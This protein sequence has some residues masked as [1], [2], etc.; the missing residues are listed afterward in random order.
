MQLPMFRS[1][2]NHDNSNRIYIAAA[3][4]LLCNIGLFVALFFVV[5]PGKPV[6]MA[7]SR[8]GGGRAI[9]V[10][11]KKQASKPQPHHNAQ[12]QKSSVHK[13]SVASQPKTPKQ[14]KSQ[15]HKP[16]QS[17]HTTEKKQPVKQ[18]D[19]Q[20]QHKPK[21]QQQQSQQKKPQQQKS[22]SVQHKSTQNKQNT[23]QASQQQKQQKQTP[24]S[25]KQ[26]QSNTASQQ[27]PQKTKQSTQEQKKQQS[28]AQ[29]ETKSADVSESS[30]PLNLNSEDVSDHV[31][32]AMV[33]E[34]TK[35]WHPPAGLGGTLSCQVKVALTHNGSVSQVS[36]EQ[37]SGVLAFDMAARAAM[38]RV[39]A[40]PRAL[41]GREVVIVFG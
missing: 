22:N 6:V 27:A 9:P 20:A 11:F 26:K 14:Q 13:Q 38:W 37:S 16:K 18:Q 3:V 8:T 10:M 28:H 25:K 34:I 24:E 2:L 19:S 33:S 35:A 12:S 40:Y 29:A 5:V 36:L 7:V 23:A 32:Q 15:Q 39:K 31:Y 21:K 4:S 17:Q 41:W 1:L 30:E